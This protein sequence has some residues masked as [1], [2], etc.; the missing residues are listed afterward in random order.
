MRLFFAAN[1]YKVMVYTADKRGAG[2]DANVSIN[3]FGSQGNSGE[4]KLDNNK[5]NFEKGSYVL[6]LKALKCLNE[7]IFVIFATTNRSKNL[8]SR[9]QSQ[10][11]NHC[12]MTWRRIFASEWTSL[13]WKVLRLA[14]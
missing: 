10:A 4:R 8:E 7:S 13:S 14:S 11:I 12:S 3:V 5:N 6:Y 9:G 2:T 1:K